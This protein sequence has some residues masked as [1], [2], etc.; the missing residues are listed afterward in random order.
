MPLDSS[1]LRREMTIP[2]SPLLAVIL[3][4]FLQGMGTLHQLTVLHPLAAQLLLARQAERE[5]VHHPHPETTLLRR[6]L[7]HLLQAALLPH[8]VAIC[9][10]S[11]LVAIQALRVAPAVGQHQDPRLLMVPPPTVLPS[12]QPAK[13]VALVANRLPLFPETCH[14]VN[15]CAQLPPPV[16][17]VAL[18]VALRP[19]VKLPIHPHLGRLPTLQVRPLP[20]QATRPQTHRLLIPTR[21]LALLPPR[22]Q[23]SLDCLLPC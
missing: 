21:V 22:A 20:L 4:L 2:P 7:L 23:W 17:L 5:G 6:L 1:P 12:A 18:V 11:H 9:Q 19:L 15:A 13:P 16:E 3:L 8:P 14:R 10:P